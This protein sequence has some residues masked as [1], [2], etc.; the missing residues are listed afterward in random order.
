M[1]TWLDLITPNL[2][3]LSNKQTSQESRL[4][5]V[6]FNIKKVFIDVFLQLKQ[7]SF[8]CIFMFISC[9]D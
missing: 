5:L 9:Y 6:D 4:T 2:Q 7:D 1:L 3:F 8:S